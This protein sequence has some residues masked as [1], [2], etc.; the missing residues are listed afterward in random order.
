VLKS[1]SKILIVINF[2]IA[3]GGSIKLACHPFKTSNQ[4]HHQFA[5]LSIFVFVTNQDFSFA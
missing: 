1:K 3:L 2:F 5:K 4:K